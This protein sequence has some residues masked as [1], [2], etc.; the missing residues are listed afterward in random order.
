M[1]EKRFTFLGKDPVL[2]R[3]LPTEPQKV[4]TLRNF[5][6]PC[7]TTWPEA[8]FRAVFVCAQLLQ[9]CPKSL[10]PQ[11]LL[12]A[13]LLCPRDSPAKNPGVGCYPLLQGIFP[14]Q[15]SNPRLLSLLHWQVGSLPLASPGKPLQ[16]C[17]G[18]QVFETSLL[19]RQRPALTGLGSA[20]N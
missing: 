18:W 16:C 13:R 20:E 12:P 11:R 19:Q 7:S 3:N 6:S 1:R 5:S 9:S 14:T 8:R 17:R 2:L 15:R 4:K 10:R